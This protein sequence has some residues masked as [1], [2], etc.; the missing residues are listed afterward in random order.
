MPATAGRNPED[1]MV[2]TYRTCPACGCRV[3][4]RKFNKHYSPQTGRCKAT[5]NTLREK[6]NRLSKVARPTARSGRSI[7]LAFGST[8][9]KKLDVD[10]ASDFDN[11]V[12]R[13]GSGQSRKR[14]SHNDNTGHR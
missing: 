12:Y 1:R 3:G 6:L 9:S 10:N 13:P 4:A 2:G 8:G 5:D 7:S 11:R 14:G